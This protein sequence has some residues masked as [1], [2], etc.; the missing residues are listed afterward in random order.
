MLDSGKVATP[1]APGF[2]SFAAMNP[3]RPAI[4]DTDGSITTYGVLLRRVNAL[5]H[6]FLAH[7]LEAGD[8]V[9]GVLHNGK[10]F[11]EAVLAAGQLGLHYV[12]VNWHV[13]SDEMTYIIQ[14]S[15]AKLVIS[16]AE[17]AAAFHLDELPKYRY[18]V[19]G[20]LPGWDAFEEL[21]A[22]EP[23]TLPA[24][25]RTGGFMGYTSGTTGRPKGVKLTLDPISPEEKATSLVDTL[26]AY[27]VEPGAGVHL[28]CSPVYHAAPGG[29]AWMFLH[30]GHT[31]LIHSKFNE[32]ATL[33]DI[34]AYRV[35]S[36]HMVPTQFIRLLRL[37]DEIRSRYD[38]SSLEI[39]L[40]AGAP[41]PVP[42][43][44]RMIEWFGPII[45]EYLGSTEGSVTRVSPQEWLARPGTVGRPIPGTTVKIFGDDGAELPPGESGI[46]YVGV[47]GQPPAFEYLGDPD[48]TAASRRGDRYTAGDFGYL[49]ADGYLF[50]Q[51]RRTDLIISGGVNLYPAEIEAYLIGHPAVAEVAVIGVPDAEWGHRPVAVV[52]PAAGFA[53]DAELSKELLQYCVEGLAAFKRPRHIAFQERI[54]RSPSGKLQRRVVRDSYLEREPSANHS[55]AEK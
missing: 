53:A 46:I 42:V 41:C 7:G 45:W 34:E 22:T 1:D 55:A 47:E 3:N 33:R 29:H 23:T 32:E 52:E 50:L 35:T 54:P 27:G 38:L 6:A 19:N 30:A 24:A 18:S 25:R 9:A 11:F 20:E 17:Q 10:T 8:A 31:L 40:H 28:V 48:K 43:K 51:D 37:S 36:S 12:P 49:D 39:V 15:H 44:R 16:D 5:S 4:I 26:A 13:T 14:D 2:Y 21:G